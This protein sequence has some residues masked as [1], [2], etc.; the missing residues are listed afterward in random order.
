MLIRD[1]SRRLT[2]LFPKNGKRQENHKKHT[3]NTGS[4]HLIKEDSCQYMSYHH[5]AFYFVTTTDELL[6]RDFFLCKGTAG[7][8]TGARTWQ[9]C[10]KKYGSRLPQIT[11]N[12]GILPY[13]PHKSLQY[14]RASGIAKKKSQQLILYVM[15][16]K[17]SLKWW[18][19][20]TNSIQYTCM[21]TKYSEYSI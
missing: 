20:K 16:Q 7:Y 19:N 10:C 1:F 9:V 14:T 6:W 5:D 17:R 11:R 12:L 13:F 2:P 21:L 8:P 4:I 18:Y 3:L 15:W